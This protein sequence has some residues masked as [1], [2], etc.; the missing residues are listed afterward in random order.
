M[1]RSRRAGHILRIVPPLFYLPGRAPGAPALVPP[2]A[3]AAAPRRTTISEVGSRAEWY[4]PREVL[5]HTPGDELLMGVIHPEA[6]LFERTFSLDEAADEHRRYIRELEQAGARVHTVTGVLLAGALTD[7]DAAVPGDDLDDLRDLAREFLTYDASALP[8]EERATAQSLLEDTLSAMHPRELVKVILERPTVHLTKT[9]INTGYAATYEVS[10]VMNLYFLRDQLITT[11]KGVVIARMSST[12]RA[13]ETRI[14][15]FVLKKL[16]VNPLYEVEGDARLEGGDFIPAG[17]VAFIGQGLRTH[18][19][20]V[21]ALLSHN[22]F[23]APRVVVVKD[24]LQSQEQMHLD[25]YFN[26]LDAGLAV[27][28][29]DRM[30]AFGQPPSERMRLRADV[31]ELDGDRYRLR[32]PD[33]DFEAYITN[34]LGYTL[35]PVSSAD[36]RHYGA[37]FLTVGPRTIFGVEGVSEAYKRA[38][39]DAGVKAKWL[40]FSSLTG[41]YGAAH[42]MTQVL[43]R[44]PA[45]ARGQ[46]P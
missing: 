6:A 13:A 39:R 21:Q 32:V 19:D 17:D 12:Q 11:A 1:A 46:G 16:G 9:D 37:N 29:K 27:L 7:D 4:E 3:Q 34:E 28:A 8:P 18:A 25:T 42:C 23:G 45:G 20:A 43:R 10:P 2:P 22:V 31:Y 15:K 26:V 33:A 36:Q 5:V 35:I 40:D 24:D 14:I 41:G 44:E 30:A 38:L